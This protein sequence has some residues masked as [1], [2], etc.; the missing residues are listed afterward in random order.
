MKKRDDTSTK[1]K[2]FTI[3]NIERK[4][5]KHL[6]LANEVLFYRPGRVIIKGSYYIS[7]PAFSRYARKD[8]YE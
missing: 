6:K 5:A 1:I 7:I 3:E 2:Y 4:I 8:I